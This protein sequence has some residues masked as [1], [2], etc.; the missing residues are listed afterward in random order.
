MLSIIIPTKN[1]AS[2]I[3]K[4][5]NRLNKIKKIKNSEI[6]LVD[7]DSKDNTRTL[8]KKLS[9]KY[10][11]NVRI[12]NTGKLDLS[13]SVVFG[14]KK[15]RGDMICVMD[16]DLQHPPEMIFL[17]LRKLEK[18]KADIVIASRFVK[19]AKIGFS[20]QRVVVSKIYRFLAKIFV[21]KS[22]NVR[23]PAAGFF[24]FRKK[25]LK[26]AKLEPVGFKILLEILAKTEYGVDKIVEIPFSFKERKKG[27]SKFNFK[28]TCVA[29]KH[30]LKLSRTSK[31][32][33]RFLKFCIIGASGLIIN[34]GLLWT[35][36]E[37]AGLF[38]LLSSVIAIETSILSNFV[39]NDIWTFRRERKGR[40]LK[41][42]FKFNIARIFALFINLGI[43][44][45]LTT[46]GIHYLISNLVG[47]AM[48]TLFTYLSSLLWVWK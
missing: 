43:L 41:R 2:N 23:D 48:V 28:Q 35:L 20:A 9:R 26:N 8:A 4:L 46:I 10:K 15:A 40:F 34:E 11:L 42:M 1:E 39:L 21:P 19:G 47:I 38:Y 17:M 32:H 45:L 3:G 6:I 16:A 31:E 14:F 12:F 30:L 18:E 24:V 25:I 7:S 13:N 29:F 22:Q 44:W 5:F 37:F 27:K 36:T 33:K